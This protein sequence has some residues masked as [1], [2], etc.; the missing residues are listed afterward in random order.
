[1]KRLSESKRVYSI[2]SFET[3]ENSLLFF[4]GML[5]KILF[6]KFLFNAIFFY[7]L[8]LFI[9]YLINHNHLLE[10]KNTKIISILRR[11][12]LND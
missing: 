11:I 9:E 1:M 5:M 3:N 10:E 4:T 7:L 6:M 2:H 12:L 8:C